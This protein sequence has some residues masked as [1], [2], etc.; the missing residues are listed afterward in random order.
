MFSNMLKGLMEKPHYLPVILKEK[1]PIKMFAVH[2]FFLLFIF[3]F[4]PFP[5]FYFKSRGQFSLFLFW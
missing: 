3:F 5:T 4:S 1:S 2:I